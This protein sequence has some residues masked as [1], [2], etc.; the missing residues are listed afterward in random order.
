VYNHEHW[1]AKPRIF[2]IIEAASAIKSDHKTLDLLG[3][4]A[5]NREF[6]TT[7][8]R[9]SAG[10]LLGETFTRKFLASSSFNEALF[11]YPNL[12]LHGKLSQHLKPGL[13]YQAHEALDL[14]DLFQRLLPQQSAAREEGE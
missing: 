11:F 7:F 12:I 14:A 4:G 2:Q 6:F 9:S 13:G 5:F 8:N 10:V 3:G 1:E